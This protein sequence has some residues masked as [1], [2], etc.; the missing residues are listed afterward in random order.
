VKRR[1]L[2]TRLLIGLG[3]LLVLVGVGGFFLITVF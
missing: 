1:S 2:M 3:G